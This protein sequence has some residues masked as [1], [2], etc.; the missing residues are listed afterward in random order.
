MDDIPAITSSDILT[1]PLRN[2][3]TLRNSLDLDSEH[4]SIDDLDIEDPLSRVY[5]RESEFEAFSRSELV[6]VCVSCMGMVAVPLLYLIANRIRV[7]D[8]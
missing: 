8:S 2:D 6:F 4:G 5:V 1:T 7:G 3:E